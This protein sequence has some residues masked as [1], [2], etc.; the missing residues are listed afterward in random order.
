MVQL[1]AGARI[2]PNGERQKDT[3]TF[4]FMLLQSSAAQYAVSRLTLL[5]GGSDVR[6]AAI[7]LLLPQTSA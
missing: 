3:H 2:P 7:T 6:V 5:P 1:R 4:F